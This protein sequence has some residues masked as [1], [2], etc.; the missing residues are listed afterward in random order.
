MAASADPRAGNLDELRDV[1]AR[2]Q[3]PREVLAIVNGGDAPLVEAEL[4]R[5]RGQLFRADGAT[6]ILAH[7]E[8]ARRGQLLG[9]LDA[10]R[11]WSAARGALDPGQVALGIMLPGKGTRLSPLTQRLHGIKP[12]FPVPIRPGPDSPW[13]T[14]AAASLYSWTLIAFHLRRL[15]FRGVAWKWGDE[16]QVPSAPLRALRMDLSR[17]D[18][19]RFGSEV[20]VTDDLALH[21]DW[22]VADPRS[23][24]LVAQLRRRPRAELLARLGA[25]AAGR[26]ARALVH[27]GSPAFSHLFLEEAQRALGDLGGWLDVDGYLFEALTCDERTWQA[28]LARDAGLRAVLADHP[29]LHAR[30]RALRARLEARRGRPL[31]I[32]VIDLGAELYWGDIGQLDKARAVFAALAQPGA[33]ADFARRLAGLDAVAPDA[34]GNRV[35]GRSTLPADGSVRD[36]VVVDSFIGAGSQVRGAVVIDSELGQACLGPGS[37]VLRSTLG[38]L[39]A[40]RDCLA[41]A[42]IRRELS[43]PDGRVHTSIPADPREPTRGLEDWCADS[44]VDP[45][46]GENYTRPCLE[47]P[48]SFEAKFAQMRQRER[49]PDALEAQIEAQLRAP[50]RAEL[51][52]RAAGP[53]AGGTR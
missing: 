29:D 51:A 42:S 34:W 45:G 32:Q 40:G 18:A 25:S 24:Q 12:F 16:P 27:V 21:K 4:E 35:A 52:R 31:E 15:G 50:L 30:A 41:F 38:R 9:M 39:E 26:Q 14:A 44:R 46:S 2:S 11:H 36:S 8:S 48:A 53:G 6:A 43:L 3:G 47:N 13:L 5:L 23:G 19:V 33:A 49:G 7:E 37:V 1:V 28:E 22:L 10:L 20:E 17:A